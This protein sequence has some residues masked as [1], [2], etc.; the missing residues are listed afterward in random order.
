MAALQD[1][2]INLGN[3]QQAR[4][5]DPTVLPALYAAFKELYSEHWTLLDDTEEL[6]AASKALQDSGRADLIELLVQAVLAGRFEPGHVLWHE[7]ACMLSNAAKSKEGARYRNA[8][9]SPHPNE[10]RLVE[11]MIVTVSP[12]R[13]AISKILYNK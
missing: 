9:W 4:N 13:Y 11:R 1:L 8:A 12:R 6:A 7:L 10:N 3:G 2:D 5:L